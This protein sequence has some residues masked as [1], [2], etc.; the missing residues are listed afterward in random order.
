MCPTRRV[1]RPSCP[2]PSWRSRRS[3]ARRAQ[4]GACPCA[5]SA[6]LVTWADQPCL[7]FAQHF[8]ISTQQFNYL[9]LHCLDLCNMCE[10]LGTSGKT[11]QPRQSY[12]IKQVTGRPVL[13]PQGRVIAAVATACEYV[14]GAGLLAASTRHLRNATARGRPPPHSISSRRPGAR[15][16]SFLGIVTVSTCALQRRQLSSGCPGWIMQTASAACC[17]R[18]WTAAASSFCCSHV[19]HAPSGAWCKNASLEVDATPPEASP[20]PRSWPR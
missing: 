3:R 7:A 15:P 10:H 11:G 8:L 17:T 6:D 16:D 4:G 20:H 9:A 13:F 12:T 5:A 1:A 14:V 19:L 18:R 2:S